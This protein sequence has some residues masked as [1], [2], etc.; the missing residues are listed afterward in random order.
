MEE[1]AKER[2]CFFYEKGLQPT[3]IGSNVVI[4]YMVVVKAYYGIG[5]TDTAL[6]TYT[7]VFITPPRFEERKA[8]EVAGKD[9]IRLQTYF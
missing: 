3:T 7:T 1:A 6:K 4:I 5:L 9:V 2:Y 8:P